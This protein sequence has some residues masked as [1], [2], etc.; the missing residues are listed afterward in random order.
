LKPCLW[1]DGAPTGQLF[2][3]PIAPDSDFEKE[4]PD[5]EIELKLQFAVLPEPAV[6]DACVEILRGLL[7]IDVV[8]RYRI[9]GGLCHYD[10]YAAG[11]RD[12]WQPGLVIWQGPRAVADDSAKNHHP[13]IS[14]TQGECRRAVY[15][16]AE[17]PTAASVRARPYF[18][19]AE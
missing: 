1:T 8:P 10:Y 9:D 13:K 12:V 15:G 17:A 5:D 14:V 7:P 3:S 6:L 2:S 19:R 16:L 11:E 18:G 4:F